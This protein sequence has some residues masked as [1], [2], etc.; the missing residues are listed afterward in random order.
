MAVELDDLKIEQEPAKMSLIGRLPG[1][2]PPTTRGQDIAIGAAKALLPDLT[3]PK[4]AGEYFVDLLGH[5]KAQGPAKGTLTFAGKRLIKEIP[6]V[7]RGLDTLSSVKDEVV[8]NVARNLNIRQPAY[9]GVGNLQINSQTTN[10]KPNNPLMIKGASQADNLIWQSG[11]GSRGP[12]TSLK[13]NIGEWL[14][15]KFKDTDQAL[16]FDKRKRSINRKDFGNIVDKDGEA[17]E[18]S[19]VGSYLKS[20]EAGTP[21]PNLIKVQKVSTR[22]RGNLAR[23][24]R[25]RAPEKELYEYAAESGIPKADID[26]YLKEYSRGFNQ[27]KKAAALNTKLGDPSDA[28]HW[29]STMSSTGPKALDRAPT[30]G[31]AARIENRFQNRSGGA[32]SSHDMNQ[33]AAEIVGIPRNWKEDLT[34]FL[35]QRPGGPNKLPN[36]MAD[37]Q[38]KDLD[39][40]LAIPV[41]ASK[42]EVEA[43][44]DD[45]VKGWRKDR[46]HWSK[47]MKSI[48][49]ELRINRVRKAGSDNPDYYLNDPSHPGYRPKD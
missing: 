24:E 37:M 40:L 45:L 47:Q 41:D 12:N 22:Q 31:R 4:E 8:S 1:E 6:A 2:A 3:D 34:L 13:D 18:I 36:W 20:V 38:S 14:Q 10:I 49:R 5:A 26:A 42:V 44:F 43:V 7:K 48:E 35:D 28:G 25:M 30:S 32:K 33:Y 27:V 46:N 21:N 9:A 16:S 11:K 15:T 17:M 19:G 39:A 23:L 29:I